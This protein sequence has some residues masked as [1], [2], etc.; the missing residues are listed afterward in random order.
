MR[1]S[2]LVVG[3][4]TLTL[5]ATQSLAGSYPVTPEAGPWMILVQ[6]YAGEPS[7]QLAEELCVSLRK[8]YKV[9]AYVFDR[10]EE[11]RQKER[12]RIAEVKKKLREQ[13]KAA[14]IPEGEKLPPVKTFNIEDQHAVLI[15]GWKDQ[16]T[17]RKALDEVRKLK[18]PAEKFMRD[19]VITGSERTATGEIKLK[20]EGVNPFKTAFVVRNPTVPL[21]PDP[22]KGKLTNL[23]EY[24][25]D[26]K[27][28]LLKCKKPYTLIVKAYQG[29][30]A[31]GNSSAPPGFFNKPGG[32]KPGQLITASGLQAHAM[33]DAL[34]LIKDSKGQTLI[35]TDVYVLHTE[36]SSYVTVGGYD[37]PDDPQ[38]LH[39]KKLLSGMQLGPEE[40]LMAQPL[41]MPVP[42]P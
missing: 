23:K 1:R 33:A 42:K 14:G 41:P 3:M 4:L 6:S 8:D 38:L 25:E 15:G 17:A 12:E 30:V 37:T 18:P 9:A 36:H 28:S 20:T 29:A 35:R 19:T 21:P 32:S 2:M 26:E 16:E 13:A 24:N 39:Y 31:V 22:E 5:A 10:G 7:A 27:Y 11:Q 40:R 34:K